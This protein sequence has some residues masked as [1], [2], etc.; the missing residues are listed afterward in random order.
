MTLQELCEPLFQYMCRLSR[1]AKAGAVTEPT[2]VRAEIKAQLDQMRSKASTDPSLMTQFEKV[3]L[4]LIF[5]VD[6]MVKESALT[7][8]RDWK[9]LAYERN[10]LAGDEKFFDLLDETLADPTEP[11]NARLMIFYTCMG[12]GFTG[13]YS[14]QPEY[15]RRKMDECRARLGA[16]MD[17]PEVS[18]VCPEA[19]EADTRDLVEPP[20]RS[21]A[22]I[23]L[24]LV[25]AVVVL[26]A[27]N[28]YLYRANMNQ[29]DKFF[30]DIIDA[31][32]PV[33]TTVASLEMGESPYANAI[34]R[35]EARS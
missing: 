6:F 32:P 12:L 24:A 15:L 9:E 5:F 33:H 35:W 3:E 34:G 1:S 23:T 20:A 4:V 29:L 25:G 27:A 26:F 14:G 28:I 16:R 2:Q 11:A 30:D 13:W 31:A 7:F 10:E 19:Y 17:A 21:L 8:A 18:R 22:T